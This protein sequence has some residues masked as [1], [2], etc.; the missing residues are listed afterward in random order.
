MFPKKIPKRE[1]PKNIKKGTSDIGD[2]KELLEIVEYFKKN[3]KAP[4]TIMDFSETE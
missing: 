1:R 3:Q 2:T 4:K